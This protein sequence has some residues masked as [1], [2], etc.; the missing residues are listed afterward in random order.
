MPDTKAKKNAR[1]K[2]FYAKDPPRRR[3]YARARYAAKMQDADWH[4][5]HLTKTRNRKLL[6]KYGITL[7]E[8]DAIFVT[9]NFCCAACG[10]PEP[11]SKTGWHTDHSHRTDQVRGILCQPCNVILGHAKDNPQTLK[12]LIAYLERTDG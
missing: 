3:A 1:Q 12:S 6:E 8:R 10:S 5:T 11:G 4:A 2:K 9:Q 7:S